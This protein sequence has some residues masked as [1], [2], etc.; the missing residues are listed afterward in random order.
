MDRRECIG[1]IAA[2]LLAVPLAASAQQQPVK[3]FR[4]GFLGAESAI[5]YGSRAEAFRAGLRD[6]GY[7]ERKNIAI[8]YRWADGKYDRLPDLAAELVRL[9]VDV[10]VAGGEKASVAAKSA[11]STTPIVATNAGDAV[12]GGLIAGLA[13]P[14]GN[15]TG[16]SIFGP[17]VTAKRLELLKEAMPGIRQVAVLMNPESPAMVEPILQA[18]RLRAAALKLGIRLFEARAPSEFESAFSTM[19]KDHVDAIV[20]QGDTLFVFNARRVADA[21]AKQRL[22]SAGTSEL[23]KAGCLIGFGASTVEG[24]RRAGHFVDKILKGARPGDLPVEQPTK[25]E[26]V[27]NLKTSKALGIT[28]PQSLLLRADEVIQ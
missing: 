17:E 11:T 10:L 7:V 18:M 20:I 28:I 25:F 8:E 14:S 12:A 1:T 23:A 13:Q 3:V 27:I 9:K 19:A 16:I 6:F 15:V 24:Y 2:Y 5:S 21:A 22:P 4:I 26:L